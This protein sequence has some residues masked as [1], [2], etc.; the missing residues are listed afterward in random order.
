[1]ALTSDQVLQFVDRVGQRGV[2][3]LA[4][5]ARNQAKTPMNSTTLTPAQNAL[6]AAVQAVPTER[7]PKYVHP[8]ATASAARAW[9]K[10]DPATG[11]TVPRPPLTAAELA[12]LQRL[13]SDPSQVTFDDAQ[14]LLQ[15]MFEVSDPAD[16]PL[17]RSIATPVR[18]YHD[19]QQARVD[20][21]AAQRPRPQ[22]PAEALPA[23]ADAIAAEHP[24]LLPTEA[25]GR[26]STLLAERAQQ[27]A[28]EQAQKA[29]QAQQR[30]DQIDTAARDRAAVHRGPTPE[31]DLPA[32]VLS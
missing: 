13:P 10:R 19:R 23:L 24:E 11:Q 26:A 3:A 28:N 12:W 14:R 21:E 2:N 20:L 18:D 17:V 31:V 4:W 16:V 6:I 8:A 29:S 5:L 32:A 27:R 9:L 1:M 25:V 7:A 30:I 15:M 22:V